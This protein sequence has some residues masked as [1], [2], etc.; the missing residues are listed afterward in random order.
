M[1]RF[2]FLFIII[3]F[4]TPLFAQNLSG[5]WVGF[6][7]NSNG[8]EEKIYPYEINISNGGGQQVNAITLTRFSNQSTATAIARGNYASNVHLLSLQETKFEQ[9]HLDAN[10]QGCLMNNYLTYKK[11]HNIETLQGTYTTKNVNN[12]T[13]CGMGTVYLERDLIDAMA[14]AKPNKKNDQAIIN[15]KLILNKL[16]AKKKDSIKLSKSIQQTVANTFLNASININTPSITPSSSINYN[17]QFSTATIQN[18][19]SSN[20][21]SM[22]NSTPKHEHLIIPWVLIS[23]EN[24]FVKKIVTHSKSISFDLFDNGSIDNDTITIYDNKRL[25]LD[26]NRL[27]YKA[28][29]FDIKLDEIQNTHEIIV[30]ANNLGS[31]P[32]N[33]ALLIYKDAK[34]SE[35]ISINTNFTQNAK[36]IIEY[37][38]PL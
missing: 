22:V 31:A 19:D 25:M 32:P 12:G 24:V 11:E 21:V 20:I 10:L 14:M 9:I 17:K 13:D 2:L 27:S 7:R 6:F 4:C 36:L 18:K 3:G 28:I 35:E 33:T 34:Q 29:H 26:Q 16:V 1:S 15:N 23:R 38:P 37:Q 8:I 5:K 30:V